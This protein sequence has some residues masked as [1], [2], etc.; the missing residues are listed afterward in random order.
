[1][2]VSG[3]GQGEYFMRLVLAHEVAAMMAYC[4]YTVTAAVE[5]AVRDRLGPAG[6]H[7]GVIAVDR[8]ARVAMAMNTSFMPRGYVTH[9]QGPT[10]ATG[11][12]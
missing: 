1:V 6:G 2:A 5:A 4:G 3:T 9:Q 10:I 8:E 12:W 7:G 11:A